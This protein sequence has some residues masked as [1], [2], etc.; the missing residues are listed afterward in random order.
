MQTQETT[1]KDL[2]PKK[3]KSKDLKSTLA[4]TNTAESLEQEKKNQKNKKK[5]FWQKK[6]QNN[7]L[8]TGDN[9]I[10]AP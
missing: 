9:A 1:V 2:H 10:D 5:K 7:T 4:C 8:A 3:A 6:E